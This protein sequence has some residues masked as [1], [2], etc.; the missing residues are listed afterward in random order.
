MACNLAKVLS[1]CKV[2]A[3]R[4]TSIVSGLG[5]LEVV[6]EGSLRIGCP[7]IIQ[8]FASYLQFWY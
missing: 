5:K 8:I 3:E 6:R 7:F 1:L 2:L 4:C